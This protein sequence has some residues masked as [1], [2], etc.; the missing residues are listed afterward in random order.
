MRRLEN[1]EVARAL[2]EIADYLELQSVAFK[3]QAYRRA[4][5]AIENLDRN[6]EEYLSSG[7]LMDIPGIGEAI[8]EKITELVKTGRMQYL[9]K[10]R[11]EMPEGI[12]QLL[13]IPD[14]GPKKAMLLYR[15][16]GIQSVEDLKKAIFDHRLQGIK[17][18]GIKTEERI[19]QGIRVVESRGGRTLLG[20]AFETASA[21][22]SHLRD[23]NPDAK[24]S[25]AGSLRR[26]KETI[27]DIDILAASDRPAEV[28]GSFAS[29]RGIKEVIAQGDTKS[30]IRLATGIQV[31]LRVV[32]PASFGAAMQYFTGS[33][34]HNVELRKLAIS[35]GMKISEYGLF[36]RDSDRIIS[37]DDEVE[38]Y[39]SLGLQF[40]P[41]E[42]RENRGEIEAASRNGLPEL[43]GYDDLKGDLHCH[44]EW[45][46]AAGTI[47]EVWDTA[48]R[49]KYEYISI[50]DHSKSLKIANG[51]SEN[52]LLEQCVR[53]K[54]LRDSLGPPWIFAGNEVDVL[55]DG[56]LDYSSE[57]LKEL[58]YAVMSVHSRFKMDGKEMTERIITG[59]SNEKVKVFAHP[60]GRLIGQRVPYTYDFERVVETA[61]QNGIALEINSFPERLDLNDM[62]VKRAIDLGAKISIDSDAHGPEQLA[63]V[64]YG[65]ATARRGWARRS[66][67]LN[68]MPLDQLMKEWKMK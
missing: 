30:S 32:P 24:I 18:F 27:G 47:E 34:D 54:K 1:D 62:N 64:K 15:E 67:I 14:I 43:I 11:K 45:S 61:R 41:P 39:R 36:E 25:M 49:M 37:A 3:P 23:R 50:T 56:K 33:K 58:D 8:S 17:G 51:L 65:I 38:I 66:D 7:T 44:T 68:A 10:L 22:I 31:D 42:L 12:L 59:L 9:A 52:R 63:Y 19:L 16:L 2:Y 48:R 13:G 5:S 20:N 4:A 55:A 57:V 29:M 26:M 46:D 6:V 60:T 28:M 35:K 53:I 40:I 21:I